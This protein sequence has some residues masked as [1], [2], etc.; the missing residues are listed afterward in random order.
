MVLKSNSPE[1]EKKEKDKKEKEKEKEK[2]PQPRVTRSTS[3][4]GKNLGK[5]GDS[6]QD[7]SSSRPEWVSGEEPQQAGIG[8]ERGEGELQAH[9]PDR[10]WFS[11]VSETVWGVS[12]HESGKHIQAALFCSPL[13]TV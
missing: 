1:K 3:A 11:R 10:T 2:K 7:A 8:K 4:K 6:S 9:P 13:N 12:E 5:G